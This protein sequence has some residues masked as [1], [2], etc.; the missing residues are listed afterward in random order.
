M[1]E[2]ESTTIPTMAVDQKWRLYWNRE[3]V[4]SR[5]K[6]DLEFVVA[7]EVTHL[8]QGHPAR[9]SR[10]IRHK[11]QQVTWNVAADYAVNS[12]LAAEG[13][14]L[15]SYVLNPVNDGF[16][17]ELT[18][19]E[20]YR[21]LAKEQEANPA[22]DGPPGSLDG[23][24]CNGN[25]M[26]A[27]SG[28][29][30]QQRPWE[31]SLDDSSLAEPE[32][33]QGSDASTEELSGGVDSHEAEAIQQAVAE[34][35]EKAGYANGSAGRRRIVDAT[36]PI[37]TDPRKLLAHAIRSHISKCESGPGSS[38]YR[39]PSRR[40]SLAGEIRPKSVRPTPSIAIIVDTSG[41][42]T[43]RELETA[44]SVIA[45]VLGSIRNSDGIR[46]V[47]GDTEAC[48]ST[49]AFRPDQVSFAGGG[50]TD[51]GAIIDSLS[52]TRERLDLI[53][54]VTD[55]DTPWTDRRPR[56]PVVVALTRSN[57]ASSVPVW[58]R[59]VCLN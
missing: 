7:H 45:G 23:A 34:A 22:D 32:Q 27:G 4:D 6:D 5:T 38:T 21:A 11:S 10:V 16:E 46:V 58:M 44:L 51:M 33:G 49:R 39:R 15:P 14:A 41:S 53:I 1:I 28:S 40:P 52:E 59:T 3:F 47:T 13:Y 43:P 17:A 29:D 37:K 56:C 35:I 26:H 18:V 9:G 25:P 42:M 24:D 19:E 2:I 31:S 36:K 55:G 20:Y 48:V 8:V 50:G 57:R 54:V 12:M 30:G